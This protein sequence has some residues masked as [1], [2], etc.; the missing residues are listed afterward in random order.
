MGEGGS[1]SSGMS[2]DP[3][4]SRSG[5]SQPGPSEWQSLAAGLAVLPTADPDG[6]EQ[7][8]C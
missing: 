2:S 5:S 1:Q 8:G 6:V 4:E 3:S 7:G